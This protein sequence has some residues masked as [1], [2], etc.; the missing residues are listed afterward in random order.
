MSH[1]LL[2]EPNTL[3]AKTYTQALKHAGHSVAHVTGAQAA[4][5]A[6]D[7]KI[8][9]LVISELNLSQHSGIEFLHEFRSY[10]EWLNVPVILNT[11]LTAAQIAPVV[12]ALRRDLGIREIL[13]KP[14]TSLQ[15][16]VR[17]AR[18]YSV[19]TP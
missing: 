13:Y 16:L 5:D 19:S 3:L 11:V 6:A 17:V 15:D 4:V 18:D 12:E 8:P 2:L 10:A 14:R 1:I 7:K 9:D